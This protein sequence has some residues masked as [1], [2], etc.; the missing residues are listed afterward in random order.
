[1][2]KFKCQIECP[3]CSKMTE[4]EVKPNIRYIVDKCYICN[5]EISYKADVLNDA[6]R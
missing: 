4:V 2:T 6:V 1:M 5:Q 3:Y